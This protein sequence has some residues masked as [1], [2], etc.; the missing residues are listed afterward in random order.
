M[1]TLTAG[2]AIHGSAWRAYL[3]NG[4][5]THDEVLAAGAYSVDSTAREVE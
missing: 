3:C 4:A 2:A 5:H 1:A